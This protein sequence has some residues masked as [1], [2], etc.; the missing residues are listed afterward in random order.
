[1]AEARATTAVEVIDGEVLELAPV[2]SRHAGCVRV[3]RAFHAGVSGRAVASAV[4]HGREGAVA[5]H[6]FPALVLEVAAIVGL[7]EIVSGSR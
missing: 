1:M 6:A 7:R 2:G 3:A 5:P 4:L